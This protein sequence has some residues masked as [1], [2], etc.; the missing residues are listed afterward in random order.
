MLT[1]AEITKLTQLLEE[2]K[3]TIQAQLWFDPKSNLDNFSQ[4]N[5]TLYF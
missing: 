1:P 3:K 5:V 2:E 4:L